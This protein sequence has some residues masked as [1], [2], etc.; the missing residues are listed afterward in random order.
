MDVSKIGN[1]QSTV[2]P[3]TGGIQVTIEQN[4]YI[5]SLSVK[6]WDGVYSRGWSELHGSPCAKIQ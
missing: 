6:I 1:T 3:H 4:V 5:T 2:N